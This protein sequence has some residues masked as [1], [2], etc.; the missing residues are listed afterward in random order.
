MAAMGRAENSI[1]TLLK[2][3][4]I[5]A[6]VVVGAQFLLD[7]VIDL[8]DHGEIRFDEGDRLLNL[9]IGVLTT[10]TIVA[11][12]YWIVEAG[13]AEWVVV[14]A[15]GAVYAA[16][17]VETVLRSFVF[18]WAEL[19]AIALLT[20]LSTVLYFL[21]FVL[22]Y[23]MAFEDRDVTDWDPGAITSKL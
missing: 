7:V 3:A 21:T 10:A 11:G 13:T 18:D 17:V 22:A 20:N 8:V 9:L 14:R 16:A 2:I 1:E 6:L 4:A 12:A 5:A 19:E 23:R 15:V